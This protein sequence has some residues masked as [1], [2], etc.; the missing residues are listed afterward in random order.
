MVL[1]HLSC[2]IIDF[3]LEETRLGEPAFLSR[4]S[5]QLELTPID[6]PDSDD[7]KEPA[8]GLER[9]RS[10]LA[11][12]GVLSRNKTRRRPPQPPRAIQTGDHFSTPPVEVQEA[13]PVKE[14]TAS[15]MQIGSVLWLKPCCRK[16]LM[17]AGSPFNGICRL[18]LASRRVSL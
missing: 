7:E 5:H 14:K 15:L 17:T 16:T 10:V 13:S 3:C 9:S 4:P 2:S 12:A 11:T 18:C 1:L 8:K 6:E